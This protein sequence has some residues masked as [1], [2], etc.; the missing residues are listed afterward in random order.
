MVSL[1]TLLKVSRPGWWLVNLWLYMAPTGQRWELF[2]SYRFWLG[3]M[4]ALFPLNLMVYGMNDYVDVKVDKDNDRKGNWFYGAKCTQNELN[5]VMKATFAINL[6]CMGYFTV[7]S[8]DPFSSFFVFLAGVVINMVYNFEPF[9]LSSKAPF[10][11]FP[12]IIGYWT[13]TLISCCINE[14]PL[15]PVR[16]WVHCALL[17]SRTLL[18]TQQFDIEADAAAGRRTSAVLLGQKR[19]ILVVLLSLLMELVFTF[20]FFEDAIF[21]GF[22]VMGLVLFIAMEGTPKKPKKEQSAMER[23]IDEKNKRWT[24]LSQN[25]VGFG[26][27]CHIWLTGLFN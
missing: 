8:S 13:V 15:P 22:S 17:V 10:E 21:R 14:L 11:Y 24:M 9:H 1:V 12:V 2:E 27:I 20:T 19:C 3:L 16:Y 23:M 7:T 18:W 5:S 6:L 26:L 4:F 25:A